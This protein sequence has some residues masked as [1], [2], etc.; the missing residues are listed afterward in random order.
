[1]K[2]YIM[3]NIYRI[4]LFLTFPSVTCSYFFSGQETSDLQSK[5]QCLDMEKLVL[6]ESNKKL[7]ESSKQKELEL[8][9]IQTRMQEQKEN[10]GKLEGSLHEKESLLQALKST[11]TALNGKKN[12]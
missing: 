6:S 9:Q 5:I 11:E 8:L 10:I 4:H 3:R 12:K 7:V 1:M 2:Y